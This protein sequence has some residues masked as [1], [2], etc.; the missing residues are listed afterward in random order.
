MCACVC[1]WLVRL[2]TRQITHAIL[3]PASLMPNNVFP[4]YN[5][6][7]LEPL[8]Q[9]HPFFS[10]WKVSSPGL[11]LILRPRTWHSANPDLQVKNSV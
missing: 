4:T 2:W 11:T 1:V 9:I 7:T 10:V 6:L 3:Q 8:V 5:I